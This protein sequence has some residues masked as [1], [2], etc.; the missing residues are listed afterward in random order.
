MMDTREV[1]PGGSCCL[2]VEISALLRSCFL[3]SVEVDFM[4]KPQGGMQG[5]LLDTHE[6]QAGGSCCP[7]I[8]WDAV[9][10][11]WV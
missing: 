9:F 11:P 6:V 10:N 7:F 4:C 3:D 2:Y 1:R 8:C 5:K